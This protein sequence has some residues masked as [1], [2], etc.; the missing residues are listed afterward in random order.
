MSLDIKHQLQL[1]NMFLKGTLS[2]DIESSPSNKLICDSDVK[3]IKHFLEI[4]SFD[5]LVC[6]SWISIKGTNYQH[7]MQW[8]HLGGG[9]LV[10]CPSLTFTTTLS[11]HIKKLYEV[12]FLTR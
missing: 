6:C 1:N 5:S 7:K 9:N 8:R 2:N 3:N 4:D 11:R 10:I 12:L